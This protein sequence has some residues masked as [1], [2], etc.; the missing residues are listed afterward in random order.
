MLQVELLLKTLFFFISLK[1]IFTLIMVVAIVF[2]TLYGFGIITPEW[3]AGFIDISD[4][5]GI[6]KVVA[7]KVVEGLSKVVGLLKKD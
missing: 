2:C 4:K 3:I 7:A 5:D 6:V 1:F